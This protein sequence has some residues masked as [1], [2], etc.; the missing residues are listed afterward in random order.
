MPPNADEQVDIKDR[1]RRAV[2]RASVVVF[3][4][5]VASSYWRWFSNL[6]TLIVL[7][8]LALWLVGAFVYWLVKAVT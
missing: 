2:N 3:L 7:G 8:V 1:S 4:L 6:L 5:L